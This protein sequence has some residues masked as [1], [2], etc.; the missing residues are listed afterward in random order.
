MPKRVPPSGSGSLVLAL[1]RGTRPSGARMRAFH[2]MRMPGESCTGIQVR[3]RIAWPCV[4]RNG[5]VPPAVCP[6][7][8]HWSA[9]APADVA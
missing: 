6:G 8:S 4:K 3:V 2:V 1:I 7:A 5:W 9:A